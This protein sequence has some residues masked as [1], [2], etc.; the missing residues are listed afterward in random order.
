MSVLLYGHLFQLK[1]VNPLAVYWQKS[2]VRGLTLKDLSSLELWCNFK[3][4]QLTEVMRQ[5]GD[6]TLI[7]LLNKIRI[8]YI[9]EFLW[10]VLKEKF[11]YRNDP[12]YPDDVLHTFAENVLV[13]HHNDAMIQQFDS[14]M[15]STDVIDQLPKGVTLFDKNL[16]SLSVRKP[17][18]TGNIS[19]QLVLKIGARVKLINN[20]NIS[21]RLINGQIGLVKYS[22]SVAG[23]ITK[24]NLS[25]DDN[26][27]GIRAVSCDTINKS[28][29]TKTSMGSNWKNR[30]FI[31]Y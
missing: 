9:D 3:I 17:T 18:D 12:I 31:Q 2:D 15:V 29:V 22:K 25:F 26:P 5:R 11:I 8:G 14:P 21:D 10:S 28:N 4:A 20:I 1:P 6:T 16:V 23:K 19:S 30:S 13:R 27:A 7:D 24:I